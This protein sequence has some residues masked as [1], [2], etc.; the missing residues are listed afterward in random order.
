[1][2][3]R[4]LAARL[5]QA[6]QL[7]PSQ[8]RQ[9]VLALP[10]RKR[11]KIEELRLRVGRPLF[12]VDPEGENP[13]T[14]TIVTPDTLNTVL[15][16]ASSS[17]VHTVLEQIK[18]GFVAVRGGHRLGLCG[19]GVVEQ[20]KLVNL[21]NLSSLSLRIAR[22]FKGVATPVLPK[23]WGGTGLESTL[24]LSPPG[25]GKTTLLRDLIR[26][27]STG[28]GCPPRRV[29]VADERGE[30]AAVAEGTPTMDLGPRS[31]VID[32]CPKAIGLTT[33]LRSMN[34]Q[35]LAVDEITAPDDVEAVLQAV[36]CGVTLLATAH[37]GALADLNRRPVYRELMA[38]RVFGRLILIQNSG[39]GRR[40]TVTDEE[41]Q[42]C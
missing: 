38:Q 36:G 21:R 5:D 10:E 39:E 16:L 18:K 31:D 26:A 14:D 7:L 28:E 40:Y 35:V 37:G 1:M 8:L 6:A 17:S 42:L 41:G 27:L 32:G 3:T 22:E 9:R 15:E 2:D 29:G 34:P 4:T 23:L 20:G 33:L 11:A 24:I 25:G 13:M 19:T 30:L 12:I